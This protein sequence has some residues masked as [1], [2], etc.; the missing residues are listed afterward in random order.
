MEQSLC[1]PLTFG[2]NFHVRQ[3]A[4]KLQDDKLLAKLSAGDSIAQDAQYHL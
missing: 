4:M 2:V 3:C 1:R